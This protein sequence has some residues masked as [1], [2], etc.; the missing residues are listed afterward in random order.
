[1]ASSPEIM[2]LES[3]LKAVHEAAMSADHRNQETLEAVHETLEQIVSKL[4]EL[5]TAAI[6]Q[7]LTQAVGMAST[8]APMGQPSETL[9][10][11]LMQDEPR[12][13]RSNGRP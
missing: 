1:M 4:T 11:P 3:G 2:A 10:Q 9:M 8:A 12:M 6:G 13:A 7:R 5:E